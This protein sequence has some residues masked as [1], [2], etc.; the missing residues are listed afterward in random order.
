MTTSLPTALAKLG[1]VTGRLEDNGHTSAVVYPVGPDISDHRRWIAD[2]REPIQACLR[3][4]GA[5]LLTELPADL[6]LFSAVVRSIGGEPLAYNERSTPRTEIGLGI[7][8]STDYPPD[9]AIPMHNENSYSDRWPTTLFFFCDTPAESGGAT[10]IANSRAVLR[11][12]PLDLRNDF[13]QGVLYTRTFRD[14]FGLSWRESFQTDSRAQVEQYCRDH[15]QRFTWTGAGLRTAHRRP[16]WGTEP[17]TGEQV[18]F[19]QANLF[20]VSSLDEEVQEALLALY[21]EQDLPRNAYFGDGRPIPPE[22]ITAVDKAYAEASLALPWQ[23]G[24]ILIINNMLTAHGREPF[25]GTR[26]IL[27]AMS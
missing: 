14:G 7:Y 3:T 18:W 8:T 27:V 20:H 2:H 21:P 17:L 13:S 9:Q 16:A 15:D 11:L 12:L 10:P 24:N 22:T 25:T 19:N 23:P 26:R 5:V 6:A 1:P 4:Q